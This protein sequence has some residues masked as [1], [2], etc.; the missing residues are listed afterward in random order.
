[1]YKQSYP[2]REGCSEVLEDP[3][4][5]LLP[6]KKSRS[7]RCGGTA[8]TLP[9]GLEAYSG[10]KFRQTPPPT[11]VGAAGAAGSP[12]FCLRAELVYNGQGWTR[13]LF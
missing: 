4:L 12:A 7:S 6:R 13:T 5:A 10:R 11:R 9:H 3:G 2:W 8:P 1:V